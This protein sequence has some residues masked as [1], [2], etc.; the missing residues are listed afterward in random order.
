[1]TYVNESHIFKKPF[2]SL[3]IG[4]TPCLA[5]F[6]STSTILLIYFLFKYVP[7]AYHYVVKCSL[8]ALECAISH[9]LPR[10]RILCIIG[11]RVQGIWYL[12]QG[13]SSLQA[14]YIRVS[15]DFLQ[16]MNIRVLTL[17][18]GSRELVSYSN[19]IE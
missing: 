17:N 4:F 13:P 1:M 6:I 15:L 12:V 3:Y 2:A 11:Q 5:L 7:S 9:G 19:P 14:G 10:T 8:G 18:R 16:L